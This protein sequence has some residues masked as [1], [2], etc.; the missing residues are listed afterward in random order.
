VFCRVL[1][2]CNTHPESK[3]IVV[4]GVCCSVLQCVAVCCSVLQGSHQLQQ[5]SGVKATHRH[6]S[7]LPSNWMK[8][9]A[10][11]WM[12]HHRNPLQHRD[13]ATH[14]NTENVHTMCPAMTHCNT[15]QHTATHCNTLQHNATHCNTLQH[16]ATH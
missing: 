6:W 7:V 10:S 5:S 15:L 14:R 9:Q 13:T 2:S 4:T 12:K 11:N 3:L 8:Q 16:T 1:I